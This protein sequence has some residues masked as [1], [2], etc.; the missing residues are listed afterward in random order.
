MSA[1]GKR[2]KNGPAVRF[3]VYHVN[4]L[5]NVNWTEE[6]E[7]F[8]SDTFTGTFMCPNERFCLASLGPPSSPNHSSP[9]AT[10]VA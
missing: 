10:N 3:R 7:V 1:L 9:C 5:V 4:V 8:V 6:I 2:T